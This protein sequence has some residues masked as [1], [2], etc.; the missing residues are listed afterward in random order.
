MGAKISKENR[1]QNVRAHIRFI[2]F[3]V[4]N[5]LD[6]SRCQLWCLNS[7]SRAQLKGTVALCSMWRKENVSDAECTAVQE[8]N[9][10]SPERKK[11][12]EANSNKCRS[13]GTELFISSRFARF[14]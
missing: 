10:I 3:K 2:C 9:A 8:L 12:H 7:F 1:S 11:A 13:F 14:R 4:G 6:R 5:L